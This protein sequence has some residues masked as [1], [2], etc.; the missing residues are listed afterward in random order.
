MGIEMEMGMGMRM[1]NK[2]E[3]GSEVL[4][5]HGHSGLYP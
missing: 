2:D 3:D 4:A 5:I 1:S